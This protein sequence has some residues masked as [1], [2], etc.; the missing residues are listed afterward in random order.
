MSEVTSDLTTDNEQD[1]KRKKLF[2]NRFIHDNSQP[3]AK[4]L[5]LKV[6]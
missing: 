5:K 6:A 2:P 4:L 3:T 1:K